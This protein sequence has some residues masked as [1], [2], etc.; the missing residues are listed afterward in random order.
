MAV[1]TFAIRM[2]LLIC[3]NTDFSDGGYIESWGL[4]QFIMSTGFDRLL[5]G[6]L[7][8]LR[9]LAQCESHAVSSAEVT[10]LEGVMDSE[11]DVRFTEGYL[12]TEEEAMAHDAIRLA[13]YYEEMSPNITATTSSFSKRSVWG[14]NTC[15]IRRCDGL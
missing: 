6:F 5:L 4:E 13:K 10:T 8:L 2:S 12:M 3:L 14:R 7:L 1:K 11:E 9:C 15:K